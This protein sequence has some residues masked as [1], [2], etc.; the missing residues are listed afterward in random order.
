MKRLV[1]IKNY[2]KVA[3]HPFSKGYGANDKGQICCIKKG[4]LGE[5]AVIL[6]CL[7]SVNLKIDAGEYVSIRTGRFVWEC[8]FD[9]VPIDQVVVHKNEKYG[10]DSID[11][12]RLMS[13]IQSMDQLVLLIYFTIT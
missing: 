2:N 3:L 10:D 8:W 11:N 13:L 6:G 1:R 5:I 9:G 4:E 12:L 7:R